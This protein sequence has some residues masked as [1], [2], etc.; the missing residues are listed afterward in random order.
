MQ[1][2]ISDVSHQIESLRVEN[3]DL[4]REVTLNGLNFTRAEKNG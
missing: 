3:K 4:S 1:R 2:Q